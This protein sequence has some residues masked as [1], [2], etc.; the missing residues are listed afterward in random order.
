MELTN[1]EQIYKLLDS[2]PKNLSIDFSEE[3]I[4]DIFDISNKEVCHCKFLRFLV[5]KHPNEFLKEICKINESEQISLVENEHVIRTLCDID[6]R[7]D[8]YIETVNYAIAIEMKLYAKDQNKQ[9]LRYY[10]YLKTKDKNSLLI[11][12]TLDGHIP[13]DISTVCNNICNKCD[14]KTL[15]ND[16]YYCISL[17]NDIINWLNIIIKKESDNSFIRAL[18]NQYIQSIKREVQT[19][20][21]ADIDMPPQN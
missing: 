14:S 6:G 1:E 13:S 5:Q 20:K 19:M 10:N 4:F 21:C 12:L 18:I 2:I 3:N 11:Y 8:L 15:S 9:L 16:N 7:I 17:Y